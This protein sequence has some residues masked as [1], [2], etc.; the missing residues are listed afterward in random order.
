MCV[1]AP[2][3]W[4][5]FN[6]DKARFGNVTYLGGPGDQ[7]HKTRKSDHNCGNPGY[8]PG[9]AHALDTGVPNATVGRQIV[10]ARLKDPR[11]KYVIFQARLHYPD[12]TTRANSGHHTHVHTSFKPGTTFDV[13]PFYNTPTGDTM[14]PEQMATLGRWMQE[15]RDLTVKAVEA[16]NKRAL[17]AEWTSRRIVADLIDAATGLDR[18]KLTKETVDWLAKSKV[19]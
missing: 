17:D 19:A 15:Q 11:V 9:Y 6:D 10:A 12:G 14:T 16:A 5:A 2:V 18:S 1:S 13:R 4:Q 8:Q 3:V 7:A